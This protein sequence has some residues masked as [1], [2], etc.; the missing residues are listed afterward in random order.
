MD[1]LNDS[2]EFNVSAMIESLLS[3]EAGMNKIREEFKNRSRPEDLIEQVLLEGTSYSTG[4]LRN[5][6]IGIYRGHKFVIRLSE[7]EQ[8]FLTEVFGT[9]HAHKRMRMETIIFNIAKEPG[10]HADI[11]LEFSSEVKGPLSD[12]LNALYKTAKELFER[13]ELERLMNC[14]KNQK[15]DE[16][17][18]R[19]RNPFDDLGPNFNLM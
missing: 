9:Q 5:S 2:L 12:A 8:S 17:P 13:S 10:K 14:E 19:P 1:D 16:K 3:N 4:L 7:N 6:Y 18:K 15:A 11:G